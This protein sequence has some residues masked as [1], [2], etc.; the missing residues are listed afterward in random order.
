MG[1]IYNGGRVGGAIAPYVVG[2][3]ASS[4]R[5]F[6][7]GMATAVVAFACAFVVIAIST[8]TKGRVLRE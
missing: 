7:I 2:A 5:G 8:E 4:V 1:I 6:Q 3:L